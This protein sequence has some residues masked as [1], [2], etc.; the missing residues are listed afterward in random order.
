VT[1]KKTNDVLRI[2]EFERTFE[3]EL[4]VRYEI[5]KLPD[6]PQRAEFLAEHA[7]DV[8]VV[9]TSGW[10]GVDADTIAALPNLQAIV[11]NGAGL[12]ISSTAPSWRHWAPRVT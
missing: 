11:N 9:V 7:T 3:D 10:P 12:A 8:R 6:G 4:A 2:G 5:P 1:V